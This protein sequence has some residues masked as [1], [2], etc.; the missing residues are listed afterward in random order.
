MDTFASEA[1]QYSTCYGNTKVFEEAVVLAIQW[2]P[3]G[4]DDEWMENQISTEVAKASETAKILNQPLILIYH[5]DPK[6]KWFIEDL[7]LQFQPDYFLCGHEHSKPM[8]EG[9]PMRQ[10]GKTVIINTGQNLDAETPCH[11]I[12]DL[13]TKT[14]LWKY[15]FD[16]ETKEQRI[17][18]PSQVSDH[19]GVWVDIKI[20]EF[21]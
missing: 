4:V 19:N 10:I 14:L 16:G 15:T 12:L 5:E 1:F 9:S 17:E 18:L 8:L 6:S 2:I 13:E 20:D 7:V 11:A 3:W 21:K